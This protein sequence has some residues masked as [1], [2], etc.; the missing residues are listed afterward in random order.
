MGVD[1]KDI[2]QNENQIRERLKRMFKHRDGYDLRFGEPVKRRIADAILYQ[3]GQSLAVFEFKYNL[4]PDRVNRAMN[5]LREITTYLPVSIAVV[6]DGK[7]CIIKITNDASWNDTSKIIPFGSP[8]KKFLDNF[9][10]EK[11]KNISTLPIPAW[12]D[13]K[14]TGSTV[15]ATYNG[16]EVQI[17]ATYTDS[18]LTQAIQ[19]S[20]VDVRPACL[21][22]FVSLESL[23]RMI[24]DKTIS[25]SSLIGMNDK[26][27]TNF[28]DNY[29]EN[30][31]ELKKQEADIRDDNNN[32]F[33][34]S[35]SDEDRVNDLTMWRLYGDTKG[36]CLVFE[37]DWVKLE[38]NGFILRPTCYNLDVL[39]PLISELS[40]SKSKGIEFIKFDDTS[41]K[42]FFKPKEY[43]IE[44]EYR[45]LYCAKHDCKNVKWVLNNSYKIIHPIIEFKLKDF[46]MKLKKVF[47]GCNSPEYAVNKEQIQ[48]LLHNVEVEVSDINSYRV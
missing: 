42:H 17:P 33:I 38:K 11:A 41:W 36:A 2:Y 30:E 21:S 45:L 6:T 34:L 35:F 8:L 5:M 4:V 9:W 14:I 40:S 22:R 12:K 16:K 39:S 31:T 20:N 27:E 32:S 3:N 48:H 1:I 23:F 15:Y 18:L 29:I 46:P 43:E 19:E 7:D 25:M 28:I 44:K 37:V 13:K 26:T 47:L 10:F 24:T